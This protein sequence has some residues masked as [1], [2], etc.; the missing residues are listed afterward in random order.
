M[1]LLQSVLDSRPQAYRDQAMLISLSNKLG[2]SSKTKELDL[3][4][5]VCAM[6]EG[7]KHTAT[8]KC[9][10]LASQGYK[11]AWE[12]CA[13][14]AVASQEG[15]LPHEAVKQLLG[16]ALAHC[17]KDQVVGCAHLIFLLKRE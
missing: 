12:L 2:L 16:F 8:E 14:L 7:D 5:A 3:R 13:Q 17:H 4:I 15:A 9:L 6:R 1:D 11:P 10:G